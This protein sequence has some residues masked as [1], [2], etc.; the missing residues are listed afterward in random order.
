LQYVLENV[1]QTQG[2]KKRSTF[3]QVCPG[4]EIEPGHLGHD[5]PNQGMI[6]T[7]LFKGKYWHNFHAKGSITLAFF[8]S[9][10]DV[11]ICLCRK[12]VALKSDH[13]RG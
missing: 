7:L 8:M 3:S 6:R 9:S 4:P 1:P 2:Y 13:I 5:S 11:R 10:L 12:S